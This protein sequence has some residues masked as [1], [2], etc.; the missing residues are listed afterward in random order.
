MR[1]LQKA[2]L[3][4]LLLV[5][6]IGMTACDSSSDDDESETTFTFVNQ[7]ATVSPDDSPVTIEVAIQNPPAGEASVEVLFA[8][9]ASSA[10]MS[11]VM[12]FETKTVTFPAGSENGATQSV[13]VE[14]SDQAAVPDAEQAYFALQNASTGSIG[15]TREFELRIGASITPLAEFQEAETGTVGII[16]GVVTRQST[17][18]GYTWIQDETGGIVARIFEGAW[19]DSVSAGVIVPGTRVQVTGAVSYY[20]GLAQ[21]NGVE[22]VEDFQVLEQNVEIPEPV[23]L[24]LAEVA[25]NGET[26]ENTLIRVEGLTITDSRTTFEGGGGAGNF[27]ITDG[28]GG[29][30]NVLLR[31]ESYSYWDGK[32]VPQG[33]VI[34]EGPLGQYNGDGFDVDGSN[35]GYQLTAVTEQALITE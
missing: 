21:I 26:Y 27:T 32:D 34:F 6:G 17:N 8:D 7:G 5:L 18:G 23:T 2:S 4:A 11:D 33:T 1:L 25:A 24:T 16:E 19:A 9:P 3:L 30:S 28:S 14:I 13:T 29:G 31:I 15:E 22:S 20:N 12:G 35:T 10:D